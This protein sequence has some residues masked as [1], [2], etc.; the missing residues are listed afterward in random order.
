MKKIILF[1]IIFC[2]NMSLDVHCFTNY[3]VRGESISFACRALKEADYETFEK[4]DFFV[5]YA[6]D[7]NNAYYREKII[8]NADVKTFGVIKSSSE[9]IISEYAYDKNTVYLHGKKINGSDPK[10]FEV[11]DHIVAKDK[12]DFYLHGIKLNVDIATFE[13]TFEGGFFKGKDKNKTYNSC[14]IWGEYSY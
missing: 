5:P 2:M 9:N 4:F 12:N 8:K 7:K 1:F 14:E 11:V 10:T 3:E 6:K 13:Y